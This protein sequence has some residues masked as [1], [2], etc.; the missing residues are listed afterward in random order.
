MKTIQKIAAL[1]LC[2]ASAGPSVAHA[3]S[4]SCPAADAAARAALDARHRLQQIPSQQSDYVSETVLPAQ[5]DAIRAYK[6]A[7]VGAIDARLA[8]S[9][10]RVEPAALQRTLA[11]TLRAS[12]KPAGADGHSSFGDNPTVQVERAATPRPLVLVRTGFDVTCGDDN[13]LAGY[14]WDNS[15]DNGGW[16]RVLRWQSDDYNDVSGAYGRGFEFTA[17][18][19]GQVVVVHGT[20]WCTSTWTHFVADVIVPANGAAPQRAVFRMSKDYWFEED[21][22]RLKTRPDGFELRAAVHSIDLNLLLVRPGIYRYRV[23]GD[24]V[25]R[26]QPAAA[27]GRDFVDEWLTVDD[28]LAREWSDPASAAAA[29][30]ARQALNE[31]R[32]APDTSFGYGAVR[33]CSTAKDRFQVEIALTGKSGQTVA[34][35]YGLIR[36]EANGFTMLG[37]QDAPEPTCRGANLMPRH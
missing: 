15:G 24:T 25:H 19:G 18:P 9:D 7:L 37:L 36:Q 27:N 32:K 3:A 23:D 34:K 14:V 31:R 2:I 21:N 12:A 28:T 16:R 4:S 33:G 20:P 6:Q 5:R 22:F 29:L 17:L 10:E 11:A 8:C 26:V 1:A 35:R 13:L 30:K